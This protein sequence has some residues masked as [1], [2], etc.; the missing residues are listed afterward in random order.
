[1]LC[2]NQP[3]ILTVGDFFLSKEYQALEL[4]PYQRPYEWTPRHVQTLLE[5]LLDF[6]KKETA[7]RYRLV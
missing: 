7:H 3:Q 4:P 1:M 6:Q 2:D 5:D